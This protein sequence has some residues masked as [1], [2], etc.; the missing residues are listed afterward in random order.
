MKHFK[1]ISNPI[2]AKAES[3]LVTEQKV[4]IFVAIAEGIGTLAGSI[5]A[6]LG[7]ADSGGGDGGGGG[8]GEGGGEE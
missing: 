2:P 4:G 6:I 8:G 3:L 7:L 5:E 1:S